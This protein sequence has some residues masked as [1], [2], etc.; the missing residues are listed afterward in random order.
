MSDP[1]PLQE[2]NAGRRPA[3][4]R[5]AAV[6]AAFVVVLASF[7]QTARR[8]RGDF[9]NHWEFGRRMAAGEFIY[10]RGLDVPY[11]PL[12]AL[13]HAPLTVLPVH[14]AQL[15]LFP[16]SLAA[17][18]LLLW[19]LDRLTRRSFP[20][21]RERRFWVAALALLLSIRFLLRDM[22]ECG[23]NLALVALSWWG[24]YLWTRG[25][26]WAGGISL[27]L[28]AALKCTPLAFL[29]YFLWKRHWK[30]A[31]ATATA[32]ALFTLGPI[33][34]MGP[35][36]YGRAIE[37]WSHYA[38]RGLTAGDPSRGVLGD[39]TVQNMSLRPALATLLMRIPPE[40]PL[41]LPAAER[42]K[43]ALSLDV[44]PRVAARIA[45]GLMAA[46]ALA[47]AWRFRGPAGR[48]DD[49]A[50]LWECGAIS[51]AILLYSP[52]TWGQHCVGVL[53]AMYLLLATGSSAGGNP[54][55]GVPRWGWAMLAAF[56][57][58]ILVLNRSVIGR[59]LSLVILGW[60]VPTA[61]L[62]GLLAVALACHA[63]TLGGE[64]RLQPV[65]AAA[66][67]DFRRAA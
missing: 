32:A 14:V 13:V 38:G 16:L 62:L 15:V 29:G 40:H 64:L 8:P 53:P 55:R 18:A 24:I 42:I 44:A 47:V 60:H 20:L 22:S 43:E 46:L 25:R 11:L 61:I 36:A 23:V 41:H 6:A 5:R 50:V 10:E 57:L 59:E 52:I 45:L 17:A 56:V 12:W 19:V 30:I 31:A 33:L 21:D 67:A 1:R 3:R 7:F 28:A 63:R 66:A 39:E 9:P 35:Q 4:L 37:F 51:L 54:A 49:A 34:W 27:G 26:D 65:G 48:R 2:T 58:V